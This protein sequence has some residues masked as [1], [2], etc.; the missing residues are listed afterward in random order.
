[1]QHFVLKKKKKETASWQACQPAEVVV[2]VH[3]G[4][5]LD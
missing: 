1:M 2:V 3:K 5:D 4:K